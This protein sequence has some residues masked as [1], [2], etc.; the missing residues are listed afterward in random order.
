[1]ADA[2]KDEALSLPKNKGKYRA[3]DCLVINELVAQESEIRDRFQTVRCPFLEGEP[4]FPGSGILKESHIQITVV[5][6][7][8]ILGVFRP[9]F[10]PQRGR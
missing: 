6:P 7:D 4:A 2:Y 1:M 3:L 9:N 10:V 8:C 5:D